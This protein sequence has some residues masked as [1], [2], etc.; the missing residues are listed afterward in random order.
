MIAAVIANKSPPAD[1]ARYDS[2]DPKGE[3]RRITAADSL[4][5]RDRVSAAAGA[6]PVALITGASRGIGAATARELARR[7][8]ALVLAARSERD[9]LGIAHELEDMGNCCYVVPT[10]LR[11]K[12]DVEELARAA[13]ARFGGVDVLIHNAGVVFANRWLLDLTEDNV[14]EVIETNLMAPIRLTRCLLPSMIERR[15]GFIGFIGSI[16]GH[17]ALP[18]GATYSTTKFGLRGFAGALRREVKEHGIKVS[19]ISPGFVSTRLADDLRNVTAR[20]RLR[21]LSAD[22]VAKVIADAIDR[23]RREI[24]VPRYYHVFTWL[25]RRLPFII[26]RLSDWILATLKGNTALPTTHEREG[27]AQSA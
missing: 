27:P 12:E 24:I 1:S 17:V 8:Y 7:G 4:P 21:M 6:R 20:L 9:L 3:S 26:D 15:S 25:E 13:L 14:A 18:A 2:P 11:R 23:P 22:H 5:M 10:D 16:G 19:I